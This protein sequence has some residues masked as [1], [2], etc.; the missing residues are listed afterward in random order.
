MV[1]VTLPGPAH[2]AKMLSAPF[3]QASFADYGELVVDPLYHV[4]AL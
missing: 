1:T 3:V 4:A 2:S